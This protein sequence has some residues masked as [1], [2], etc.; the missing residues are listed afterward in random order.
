[1]AMH[2]LAS[3]QPTHR[4]GSLGSTLRRFACADVTPYRRAF[5]SLCRTAVVSASHRHRRFRA[6]P[7]SM[8][9]VAR[10]RPA[11]VLAGRWRCVAAG[12]LRRGADV[13]V[14]VAVAV[15]S[16]RRASSAKMHAAS[17][18]VWLSRLAAPLPVALCR[19][20]LCC[21]GALLSPVHLTSEPSS[22]DV[23][24]PPSLHIAVTAASASRYSAPP[25]SHCV[26]PRLSCS[27]PSL[28]ALPPH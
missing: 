22:C 12:P 27:S 17:R 28:G 10:Q 14:A 23:A 15:Q 8:A 26:D 18:L 7:L 1:M 13:A 2:G 6:G 21:A 19:L 5:A 11:S 24:R 3:V 20:A 9:A 25:P 16:S 4:A